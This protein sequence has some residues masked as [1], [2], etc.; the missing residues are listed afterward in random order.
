MLACH[1]QYLIHIWDSFTLSQRLRCLGAL[2]LF[3][4]VVWLY[5]GQSCHDYIWYISSFCYFT[6]LYLAY[7]HLQNNSGLF[8][9][10]NMMSYSPENTTMAFTSWMSCHL[11]GGEVVVRFAIKGH[12]PFIKFI[13]SAM[14]APMVSTWCINWAGF[15]MLFWCSGLH[16]VT[17]Y[18]FV[19]TESSSIL[20]HGISFEYLKIAYSNS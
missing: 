17:Y 8:F 7:V 4:L 14:A 1:S 19:V 18:S 12:E 6:I 3:C 10:M 9:S 11:G 5:W 16:V 13:N 2:Y 20:V 15:K